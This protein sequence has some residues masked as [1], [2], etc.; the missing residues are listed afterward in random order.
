MNHIIDLS[1]IARWLQATG[2][3]TITPGRVLYSTPAIE[4]WLDCQCQELLED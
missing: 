1:T 3:M 4:H 2:A